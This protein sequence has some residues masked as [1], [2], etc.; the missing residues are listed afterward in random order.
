MSDK[1]KETIGMLL[2]I[3]HLYGEHESRLGPLLISLCLGGAPIL[4]Y[5]YFGLFKYIPVWLFAPIEV[6]IIIRVILKIQGRESYRMKIFRRQLYDEYSS[7]A[8]YVNVK[9]IH[10]SGCIEFVNGR[11]MFLVCCFNGTCEDEVRRSIDVRKLLTGLLGD[12]EFDIYIHNINVS[13]ELREYYNKV[14]RFDRNDSARNF[15]KIIDYTLSLTENTSLVQCTI[16]A[17]RGRMSDWKDIYNQI[18]IACNSKAA[19][20]YKTI[21]PVRD[22]EEITDILNRDIDS[23]VQ[24]QELLRS[25][26]ATEDYGTSK[27]L[28]YDLPEDKEIVQGKEAVKPIIPKQTAH[29]FHTTMDKE[30]ILN[31]ENS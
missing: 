16:F 19:K 25:K 30:A 17:V 7:T 18:K 28:A 13:P 1:K 22:P 23:T 31:E 4:F 15:I 11:V 9:T 14:N 10:D 29:G 24:I 5:V 12:Y 26:Y 6:F 2:D 3:E 20:C 8:Q 21:Y 27:V